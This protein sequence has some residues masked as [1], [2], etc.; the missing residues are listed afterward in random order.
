MSFISELQKSMKLHEFMQSKRRSF[1]VAVCQLI[2]IL[3]RIHTQPAFWGKLGDLDHSATTASTQCKL[4]N[5]NFAKFCKKCLAFFFIFQL[6]GVNKL[7]KHIST[8]IWSAEHPN[9]G[10]N[11]QQ[12]RVLQVR[13]HCWF[14]NSV[15]DSWSHFTTRR[16][17]TLNKQV[18]L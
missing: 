8:S 5:P 9:A 16:P 4:K 17:H 6:F 14:Y 13:G 10:G 15:F 3:R 11:I 12:L 2:R 18:L 7:K 1:R